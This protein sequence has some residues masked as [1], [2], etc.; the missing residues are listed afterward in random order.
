[1]TMVNIR[2]FKMAT[3]NFTS[4]FLF[5]HHVPIIVGHNAMTMQ[6]ESK[7]LCRPILCSSPCIQLIFL[8]LCFGKIRHNSMACL[9]V[10]VGPWNIFASHIKILNWFFNFT[11][12]AN[13]MCSGLPSIA[14]SNWSTATTFLTF[15]SITIRGHRT[16]IKLI[17]RLL[18]FTL[19][20][21]LSDRARHMSL[22]PIL[23]PVPL[24]LVEANL[25]QALRSEEHTS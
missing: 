18:S 2:F 19:I 6:L 22:L 21:S 8:L 11:L 4:F 25:L 7:S 23:L 9:A 20:T 17:Q 16:F 10:G 24:A 3:T 13:L 15:V 5:C 14:R 12:C 1:M